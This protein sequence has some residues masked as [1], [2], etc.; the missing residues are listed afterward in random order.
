M[1]GITFATAYDSLGEEGL[2]H[3]L[4]E[5]EV[6]GVFTNAALL[7][8]VAGVAEKTPTV[9]VVIYDGK[10]EDVKAGAIEQLE[11]NGSKVYHLDD[12]LKLGEDNLVEPNLPEP[13]DTA[14]IMYTSGST[15]APKGVLLSNKNIVASVAGVERLLG[16]LL[17]PDATFLAYLPLAHIFELAVEMTLVSVGITMGYGQV[18]TL[19]DNSVR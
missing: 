10:K 3:S 9:K 16:E 19:T 8:I 14:C 17:T 12:F 11:K 1:Q 7:K 18:K 6:Y 2:E 15:G 4:N 13:D 5:P